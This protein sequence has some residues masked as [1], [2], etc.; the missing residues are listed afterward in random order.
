MP[1][2]A[3]TPSNLD[4]PSPPASRTN[5]TSS[6]CTFV[7]SGSRN[8]NEIDTAVHQCGEQKWT[9]KL[10]AGGELVKFQKTS[11]IDPLTGYAPDKE[12]TNVPATLWRLKQSFPPVYL[13]VDKQNLKIMDVVAEVDKQT[14]EQ[15]SHYYRF[16]GDHYLAPLKDEKF[17][18]NKVFNDQNGQKMSSNT[19]SYVK[20][21]T[22][23]PIEGTQITK[24]K[25]EA[26][27]SQAT[28]DI[29]EPEGWTTRIFKALAEMLSEF[30]QS[31]YK[32]VF[33]LIIGNAP[34]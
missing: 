11:G 17:N 33:E 6:N 21:L 28:V 3:K 19:K 24:E 30:L 1:T 2:K 8:I 15:M 27:L 4:L 5:P 13:V 7:A 34:L 12:S 25:P 26:S 22:S 9:Y 18:F 23:L 14:A 10:I 32:W 31:I 29:N 16:M 20:N